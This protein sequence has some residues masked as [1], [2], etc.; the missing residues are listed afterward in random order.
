MEI[1]TSYLVT[2]RSL[3]GRV[4]YHKIQLSDEMVGTLIRGR[5]RT[6]EML[7]LKL[8]DLIETE[9]IARTQCTKPQEMASYL[10]TAYQAFEIDA[11]EVQHALQKIYRDAKDRSIWYYRWQDGD[12]EL[13]GY[14]SRT[15]EATIFNQLLRSEAWKTNED[16]LA[17][18]LNFFSD[19][20]TPTVPDEH[21]MPTAI[22]IPI[23]ELVNARFQT[24]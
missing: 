10:H 12:T 5:W 6:S 8:Q 17:W 4:T 23:A 19:R 7:C 1:P 11:F 18:I 22:L 3:E 13:A 21:A 20:L 16:S 9:C 15:P 24:H 2:F 14:T